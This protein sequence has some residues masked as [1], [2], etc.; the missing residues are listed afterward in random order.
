MAT[1]FNHFVTFS[2]EKL[3]LAARQHKFL[4]VLPAALVC[5]LS[6]FAFASLIALFSA[7]FFALP[8]FTSLMLL[9]IILA[10]AAIIKLLSD[11]YYHFYVI[12]SRKI[13]EVSCNPL[14]SRVISGLLLEQVRITEV[15]V[16][17]NGLINDVF[18]MGHVI[19]DFDRM[20][21]NEQFTLYNIENPHETSRLLAH[22]FEL[23]MQHGTM[24]KSQMKSHNL[25]KLSSI[26]R[27]IATFN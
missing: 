25:F 11:W 24:N 22:S 3:I 2:D 19:I 15:D 23:I 10:N 4:L 9:V 16:Q 26:N 13:I 27:K 7:G 12:T 20:A 5:L 14:F 21:H 1:D 18:N 17:V 6:V 8:L